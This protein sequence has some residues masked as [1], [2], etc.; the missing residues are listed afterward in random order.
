MILS[1]AFSNG[2]LALIL[3]N[4]ISCASGMNDNIQFDMVTILVKP[5][6]GR[7]LVYL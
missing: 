3:A 1:S 5:T 4:S 2:V 6:P 7:F